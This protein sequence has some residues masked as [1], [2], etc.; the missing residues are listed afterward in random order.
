MTVTDGAVRVTAAPIN[1]TVREA[2]N[3]G[4][5]EPASKA[6]HN[7]HRLDEV[8]F[9][10]ST[11]TLYQH[12]ALTEARL[13]QL[14]AW[15]R[16]RINLNGLSLGD[17]LAEFSRYERIDT[18]KF[19]DPALRNLLVGGEMDSAGG[20]RDFVQALPAV[21]HVR[22]TIKTAAD[23]HTTVTVSHRPPQGN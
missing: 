4:S 7:Y 23:G 15:Q 12:P 22:C 2:F 1:T 20:F 21:Y 10:E 13:S 16:G 19:T 8:E 5:D 18:V 14:L 3:Q 17:A 9:D 6:K 11:M